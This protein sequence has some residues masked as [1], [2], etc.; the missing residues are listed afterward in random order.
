MTFNH[1]SN[2]RIRESFRHSINCPAAGLP[3]MERN[4][5]VDRGKPHQLRGV[6]SCRS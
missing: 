3:C 4:D 1:H 6:L 5:E 2:A